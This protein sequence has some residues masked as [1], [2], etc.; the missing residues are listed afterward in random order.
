MPLIG[1][2]TGA[3]LQEVCQLLVNEVKD[4]DGIWIFDI[5]NEGDDKHI[6][7]ESS[8]RKTPVHSEL[9]RLGLLDFVAEMRKKGDKLFPDITVSKATG[10]AGSTFSKR[11][12][13]Y[14]DNCGVIGRG[15]DFHSFRHTLHSYLRKYGVQD[16][17]IDDITGHK[18]KTIGGN[19]GDR[20][21]QKVQLEALEKVK[22]PINIKPKEV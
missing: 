16:G 4:I 7:T 22:Y 13:T 12:K 8:K 20:H 17:I 21:P 3:R 1:L 2:Y 5:N 19:Y 14:R 9:I 15:Y 6:K 10:K 18:A 11:F